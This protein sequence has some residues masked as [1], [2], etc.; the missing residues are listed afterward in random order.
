M[1]SFRQGIEGTTGYCPSTTCHGLGPKEIPMSLL[2]LSF[3][4]AIASCLF[5]PHHLPTRQ[6]PLPLSLPLPPPLPLPPVTS[7]PLRILPSCLVLSPFPL[8]FNGMMHSLDI[9]WRCLLLHLPP[10]RAAAPFCR[11]PTR[12]SPILTH[13]CPPTQPLLLDQ[14]TICGFASTPSP[15]FHKVSVARRSTNHPR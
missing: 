13:Q 5:H 6:L 11:H 8:V 3:V 1:Y 7:L 14:Q 9:F 10:T 4:G 15:S 12:S 2:C